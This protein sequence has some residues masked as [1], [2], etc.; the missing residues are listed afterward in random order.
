[1]IME[2]KRFKIEYWYDEYSDNPREWECIGDMICFHKRYDLGDKHQFN[3]P[4]DL[5]DFL[6]DNKNE[7]VYLPIYAYEH[8]GI[9]ISTKPYSCQ[10]DSGQVG[11]IY[12]YRDKLKK[13]GYKTDDEIEYVLNQEVKT[14]DD[15]LRGECYGFTL[16]D[17]SGEMLESVGGFLGDIEYCENESVITANYYDNKL[18]MQYELNF[19]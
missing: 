18:P 2:Y 13:H 8:G 5:M 11:V 9:T 14:F 3:S 10:W 4:D 7:I 1:M 12:A 19:A 16:Y 17:D 6:N 15:Y